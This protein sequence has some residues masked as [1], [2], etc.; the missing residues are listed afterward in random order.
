MSRTVGEG[1]S[2]FPLDGHS[3]SRWLGQRPAARDTHD[4]CSFRA[5]DVTVTTFKLL[6]FPNRREGIRGAACSFALGESHSTWS[7]TLG[8]GHGLHIFNYNLSSRQL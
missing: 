2:R 1:D 7:P 6:I 8:T 5:A 3:E 4:L